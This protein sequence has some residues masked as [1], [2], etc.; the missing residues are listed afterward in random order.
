MRN[1]IELTDLTV[2]E[3]EKIFNIADKINKGEC[4]KCFKGKTIILFFPYSSIRTRVTFEKG[5]FDLG[6]QSILFPSDALDKKEEIK[7]VVNYLHN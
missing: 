2:D 4:E 1:L 3:V 6:G 7:D 5:I